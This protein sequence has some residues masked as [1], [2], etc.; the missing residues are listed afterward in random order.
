MDS[1]CKAPAC[2]LVP[3]THGATTS[4][5]HSFPVHTPAYWGER[6]ELK[7][8]AAGFLVFLAPV[9]KV[10]TRAAVRMAAGGTTVCITQGWVGD[11]AP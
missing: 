11:Q 5:A 8:V 1:P 2:C 6:G 7:K 4:G 3:F 9:K 10:M